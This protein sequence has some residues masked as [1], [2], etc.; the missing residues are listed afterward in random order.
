MTKIYSSY[1]DIPFSSKLPAR[2]E[3][4]FVY[5]NNIDKI[6]FHVVDYIN[7]AGRVGN[8]L[9]FQYKDKKARDIFLRIMKKQLEL[10]GKEVIQYNAGDRI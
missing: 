3:I 6:Y 7:F 9:Y 1:N 4:N 2:C 10:S 5:S 8:T